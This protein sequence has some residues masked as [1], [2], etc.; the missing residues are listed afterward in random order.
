[1]Y[2]SFLYYSTTLSRANHYLL[3]HTGNKTLK[4]IFIKKNIFLYFSISSSCFNKLYNSLSLNRLFFLIF[5]QTACS[6]HSIKGKI[7]SAL[8]PCGQSIIA[9]W[10]LAAIDISRMMLIFF[11]RPRHQH[12]VRLYYATN[13]ISRFR[14][15]LNINFCHVPR[16]TNVSWCVRSSSTLLSVSVSPVRRQIWWMSSPSFL[17]MN[18]L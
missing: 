14:L 16:I 1:M 15:E 7:E 12:N 8:I 9:H 5:L 10:P 2:E 18:R 11:A 17:K 3:R 4:T 13:K 6:R